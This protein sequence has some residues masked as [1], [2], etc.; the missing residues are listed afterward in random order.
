MAIFRETV[1]I[2]FRLPL[3]SEGDI[4]PR[5]VRMNLDDIIDT[6]EVPLYDEEF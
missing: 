2:A 5:T 4:I 3:A 1:A 6:E